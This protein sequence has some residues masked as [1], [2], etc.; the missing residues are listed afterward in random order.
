MNNPRQLNYTQQLEHR[1]N[2]VKDDLDT[3]IL[4]IKN[5][6]LSEEFEKKSSSCDSAMSNIYN[7]EIAC[8]LSDDE[9]LSWG[10]LK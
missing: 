10:M 2:M 6:N 4:F 7:I 9:S 8:D 3:I 5:N 1:L